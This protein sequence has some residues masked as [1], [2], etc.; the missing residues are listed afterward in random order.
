[1]DKGVYCLVFENH[2]CTVRVGALGNL[3]FRAGWHIYVGSALGSGGLKRLG[4]HI[5]LAHLRDKQPKWHVDYLLTNPGFS[6]RYAIFA[7]TQERCEC[8][9]AQALSDSG[10]PGFGCSDCSCSSHLLFR[11]HDPKEEILTA[12]RELTSDPV[13]K[14]IINPQV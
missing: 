12:F 1:M 3:T 14:T 11:Q 8:R 13:I 6:L 10:I 5:S 9:L 4:R 2:E 7:V